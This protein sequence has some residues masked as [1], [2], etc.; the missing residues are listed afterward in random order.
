MVGMTQSVRP[1]RRLV[2]GLAW[3]L[4]ASVAF[5][6]EASGAQ[7]TETAPVQATA[8]AVPT[9]GSA[10]HQQSVQEVSDALGQRLARM[11][12]SKRPLPL[13]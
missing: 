12:A 4:V 1:R 2:Q 11:V 3:T 10:A 5:A 7:P 9:D 6:G 8:A 13:R